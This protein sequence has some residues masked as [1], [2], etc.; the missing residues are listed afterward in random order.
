[1]LYG[2]LLGSRQ[3]FLRIAASVSAFLL[4]LFLFTAYE[5]PPAHNPQALPPADTDYRSQVQVGDE[6]PLTDEKLY[7]AGENT[8][9]IAFDL[10]PEYTQVKEPLPFCADRFGTAYLKNLR[11][12]ATE[13]CSAESPSGLTCFHSQTATNR[14]D[15][16]CLARG[17]LFIQNEKAFS[18]GC[19]LQ[20]VSG[21]PRYHQF[22]KYWYET[23]PGIVLEQ[24]V[25][26]NEDISSITVPGPTPN[27][28]LLIKREGAYNVW[29][30]LMEIFSMTLTLD[31]LRMA[32]HPNQSFP[33][34]TSEDI[35]NT[36]VLLLDDIE[37]GPYFD[38]WHIFAAKPVLRL[39]DTSLPQLN[40][41]LENLIVPLSGGSNPLWQGDWEIHT[42]DD[43]PLL[44]TFSHRVLNHF[45]IGPVS[46]RDQ[47]PE[48]IVTFINR[49]STRRLIDGEAYFD[50]LQSELPHVKIQSIDFAT[51]SFAEQLAIA[52]QTDVLVGVHGAGLTH[53]IFLPP[54]SAIV[55]ILPPGLN[56]KGFRNVAGLLDHSYFSVHASESRPQNKAVKSEWQNDDV[57]IEQDKFIR[58]LIVAIKS[59][60]NRGSRNY[61]LE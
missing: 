27:Y 9:E 12:S 43:S 60:Y 37:E 35:Q 42:C 13:Y 1:M 53:G 58:A 44:R 14:V 40:A 26:L 32:R 17:A 2:S 11:D 47:L 22:S 21:V 19:E 18:L 20:D 41:S 16:F 34:F 54:R 10:P 25:R 61:D 28:T 23:G 38:L 36:R 8:P 6:H 51:I 4:V 30:S 33:L 49:T 45:E 3:R 29:H 46:P 39:S 31:V 55:E 24:A 5:L 57:F 15:S 7:P 56:H 52:Q 50:H 48:I 59:M